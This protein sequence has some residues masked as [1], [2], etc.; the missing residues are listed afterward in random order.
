MTEVQEERFRVLDDKAAEWC[1]KKIRE[2]EEDRAKWKAHY[3]QQMERVN[4]AADE[5]VA[6]FTAL[7][8][9]YFDTVPHKPAK[10]QESY[11]LPGGKLVRKRQLPKWETDDSKLVPWL[12]A[13]KMDAL[14]KVTES[15]DWAELKKLVT[16]TPDGTQAATE[17]GEIIP[18]I[19]VTQ[20]EDKFTVEVTG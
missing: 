3:E 8:E 7:L 20:R 12:K 17:D 11:T 5:T 18:G 4:A 9:E 14:V 15:A 1:L 13:N 6:Y 2:A 19:K 10:T 16:V